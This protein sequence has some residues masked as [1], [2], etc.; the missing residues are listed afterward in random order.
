[1]RPQARP[2]APQGYPLTGHTESPPACPT[3]SWQSRGS[4]LSAEQGDE[5]GLARGDRTDPNPQL[6]QVKPVAESTQGLKLC[7]SQRSPGGRDPQARCQGGRWAGVGQQTH[8]SADGPWSCR[9]TLAAPWSATGWPRGWS[10]PAPASAATTRNPPSTPASPRTWPGLTAL[11][12]LRLWRETHAE[13]SP[14][15]RLH[16]T[17]CCCQ[18]GQSTHAAAW[19]K[20]HRRAL[21]GSHQCPDLFPEHPPMPGGGLGQGTS[22]KP[23][24][25]HP[26]PPRSQSTGP[27]WGGRGDPSPPGWHKPQALLNVPVMLTATCCNKAMTIPA[28]L[29]RLGGGCMGAPCPGGVRS[30]GR[31][32]TRGGEMLKLSPWGWCGQGPPCISH[33]PSLPPT[34]LE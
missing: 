22:K 20:P 26:W 19:G 10:R 12:P 34:P 30:T 3:T 1:M 21:G 24:E 2:S 13:P 9:E 14:G 33:H 5:R 17:A 27:S 8:S 7:P 23:G 25:G 11:W 15:T 16:A 31:S 6:L 32:W 4:G 29:L 28:K 18:Y